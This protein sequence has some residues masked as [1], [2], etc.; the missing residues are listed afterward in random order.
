MPFKDTK[1]GKTH[2][3]G[4]GCLEHPCP[5]EKRH[6]KIPE[7]YL[8]R[9]DWMEKKSKRGYIQVRCKDCKL[10]AIWKKK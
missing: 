10:F 4:D 1:D 7:G 5:N 2:S 6:T 8:E 3:F 9:I